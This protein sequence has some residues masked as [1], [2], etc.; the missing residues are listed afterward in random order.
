MKI[1]TKI[2][3]Y[4]FKLDNYIS[5]V[6]TEMKISKREASRIV[7]ERLKRKK[8]LKIS[9]VLHKKKNELYFKR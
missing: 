1:K 2:G 9:L 3:R 6:A 4:D 8:P 7:F 5:S